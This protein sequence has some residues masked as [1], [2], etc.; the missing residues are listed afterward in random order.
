MN[1]REKRLAI[2][3]GGIVALMVNY[4]LIEFFIKNQRQLRADFTRK[5]QELALKRTLFEEKAKWEQRDAWV[6]S[7]QPRLTNE[8]SAG[9]ALLDEVKETAKK[10]NVL[11]EAPSIGTPEKRAQM[12]AVTVNIE[13]K[14]SW[15]SLCGFLREMQGP[16]RFIVFET[17]NIQVDSTDKTQMRG[18]FRVAKWFAK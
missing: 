7:K 17:A 15:E 14:G 18:K 4:W 9:V 3:V 11:V 12:T 2:I 1:P 8:A 10:T 13:T 16:E 6:R 5:T